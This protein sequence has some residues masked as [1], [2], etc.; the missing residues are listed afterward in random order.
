MRC[1][2]EGCERASDP[3]GEEMVMERGAGSKD[4]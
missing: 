2:V 4:K 1:G 3:H